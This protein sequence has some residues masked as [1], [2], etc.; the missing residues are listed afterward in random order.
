MKHFSHSYKLADLTKNDEEED[1]LDMKEDK[2]AS[3]QEFRH[4]RTLSKAN[5][6]VLEIVNEIVQL[7]SVNE[8]EE[9]EEIEDEGGVEEEEKKGESVVPKTGEVKEMAI[10]MVEAVLRRTESIP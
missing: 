1:D 6:C 8:E 2:V 4:W 7:A 10:N 3:S 5:S 9:Y